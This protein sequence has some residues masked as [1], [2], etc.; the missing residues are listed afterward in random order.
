M[1]AAKQTPHGGK[2]V[3]LMVK[4][5]AE[6]KKI[7]SSCHFEHQLT[8]RQLCDVELI[9]NGGLSPLNGFMN[10]ETYKKVVDDMRLPSGLLF[11]L[12]I[13]FDTNRDDFVPGKKVLLKQGDRDIAVFTIEDRFKPDKV[14]ECKQCYGVTTLEHPGVLMVSTERGAFYCGGSLQGLN[15][16]VREFPCR[17][18]AE[19]RTDLPDDKDVVAFQCRNPV[20][21]A[22]YE[23]FTRALDAPE[24][25][26]EG[27]V[28][29]HPTC[30]PTQADDIPGTVRYKTYVR[31]AEETK[32]PRI[33]WDYLPYSMHMAG[34]RE[35]IQHMMIRKNFG[36]THFIIGRDM[37]GSKSS[38]TGDDFYGPYDAQDFAKKHGPELGVTPV[39]SLNLVY[40]QEKGYVTAEQ[41]KEE[42]LE[43][44]KLSGTKFRKMLRSGEDIPEWF[45][46]KSVVEVLREDV[47]ASPK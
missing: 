1:M 4:D 35:A 40:T 24:V 7:A 42:G 12:P 31:L 21:R 37:A 9:I 29:V 44:L 36:C 34:P 25:G 18:P 47:L 23:L 2:L 46:F 16:P 13:V 27:V 26:P 41:A 30:G 39:P 6:K 33:R 45:A 19:V 10:E 5:E 20:H 32:N 15:L 14:H 28:L 22:H 3:D 17:T 43:T 38:I 8:D 11:G